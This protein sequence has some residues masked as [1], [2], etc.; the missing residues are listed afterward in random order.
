MPNGTAFPISIGDYRQLAD[1][2]FH[3]GTNSGSEYEY[4][5]EANGLHLYILDINR[6]ETGVL[7][8]TVGARSLEAGS[9]GTFGVE[10]SDGV[11]TTSGEKGSTCTFELTNTGSAGEVTDEDLAEYTQSDI[12]RLSAEVERKGWRVQLP[13]AL[14]V[15]AYGKST[16]VKVAVGGSG[17]AAEGEAVVVLTAT[18]ESDPGVSVVKECRVGKV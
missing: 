10:M 3:A 9:P 7:R 17:D 4:V 18:S 15:A 5:D 6:D 16:T 2:L 13:N 1:A 8:Y 11:A 12:Y 14:A